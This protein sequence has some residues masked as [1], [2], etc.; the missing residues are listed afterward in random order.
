MDLE[1]SDSGCAA[2]SSW[3]GCDLLMDDGEEFR[4]G[5]PSAG[6]GEEGSTQ[7]CQWHAT[8]AAGEV[9]RRLAVG[10]TWGGQTAANSQTAVQD[11]PS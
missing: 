6:V 3:V 9:Y 4:W 2:G 10:Q 8:A 1:L 11:P 7:A 5:W